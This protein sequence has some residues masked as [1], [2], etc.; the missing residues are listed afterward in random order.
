MK[1]RAQRESAEESAQEKQENALADLLAAF[2][3]SGE[4]SL[5]VTFHRSDYGTP[6]VTVNVMVG[7]P[8][9]GG[10]YDSRSRTYPIGEVRP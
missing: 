4:K 2:V 3:A 10:G 7:H 8:Q 6:T 9:E 5:S 1:A